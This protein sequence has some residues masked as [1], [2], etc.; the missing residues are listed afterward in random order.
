MLNKKIVLAAIASSLF[1]AGNASA[2]VDGA[3]VGVKLGEGHINRV[4]SNVNYKQNGFAQAIDLGYQINKNFAAEAGYTHFANKSFTGFDKSNNPAN[5]TDK[6]YAIS[7]VAKGILPLQNG[8]SLFG[9]A[10][11]AYVHETSKGTDNSV[12]FNNTATR[13]MPTVGLGASYDINTNLSTDLSWS[14]IQK[15]SSKSAI[16]NSDFF[17]LGLAYHFG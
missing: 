8:F 17:G 1:V 13:V 16:H 11:A 9:T 12:G 5:F 7:L 10:G 15:I 4:T 2:A 3:Y 14:H 6:N